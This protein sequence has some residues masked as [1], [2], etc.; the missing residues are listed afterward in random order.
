MNL[1]IVIINWN[2]R[3]YLAKCLDSI[4]QQ[5]LSRDTE[6]V[7]VDG[8]SFD[9]SEALVRDK[10]PEVDFIQSPENIGYGRCCNLGVRAARGEFLLILNPDTELRPG[11]VGAMMSVL[12]AQPKIGLVGARLIDPDGTFQSSSTH[13]LPGI[14][15]TVFD[16][17][18]I[19]RLAWQ[20]SGRS[21]RRSPF[22]VKAVSGAC[23]MV[24]TS[25]FKKIGGFN[26]RFFMYGEDVDL[27]QRVR[28]TGYEV[29]HVPMAEV[30]HHGGVSSAN[31]GSGFSQVMIREAV[32]VF[33]RI[34]HGPISAFCCRFLMA[35]SALARLTTASVARVFCGSEKRA[36]LNGFIEKWSLVL[37]WCLGAE[38]WASHHYTTTPRRVIC[39]A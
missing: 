16:C 25:L 5:R 19:R 8:A 32:D 18:F 12:K 39:N 15:N 7:V 20:I 2:S 14:F 36:I 9:G 27:C 23:M 24:R 37:R 35:G 13:P 3:D 28:T 21:R 4:R 30:V 17:A 33:M 26:P 6:V 31:R 11:A 10:F 22:T 29:Y 34:H 38:K 1:T